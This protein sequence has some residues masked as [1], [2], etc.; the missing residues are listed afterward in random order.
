M[1]LKQIVPAL[2][3]WLC[4]AASQAGEV[5]VLHWWTSGGEAK[6]VSVLKSMVEAQGNHWKNFAVAGGGGDS[7]MTVLKTRVVS[8]NPPTAAQIKGLEIQ[9]WAKLGFL[10]DLN[11]VAKTNNWDTILPEIVANLMKYQGNYVA[12]PVNIHRVNWLWVNSE[13]LKQADA[14]APTTLDE[15]YQVAE[16][17]KAAGYIPL[18]HGGEPWQDITLF[19]VV[20]LAVLGADGFHKALVELD[21]AALSSPKMVE[22][23]THFR[24]MRDYIDPQYRGRSWFD[25]TAMV[26]EGEAAMQL[27]GD[28]AKGEFAAAGKVPG[29]DYLCVAAPG[30]QGKFT[31]NIDSFVFY[32]LSNEENRQAQQALA[33]TILDKRFQT[34]F[35]LNKG[36]MPVRND[37]DMSSFD[38]C[39]Q[40]SRAAFNLASAN[41]ALVPSVSQGMALTSYV[42]GAIFDVVS[43]FFNAKDPDPAKAARR[44][45]RAVKSAL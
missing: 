11:E 9:E 10:T 3:L 39:A 28:W 13:V 18:A 37:L 42:Q 16:Q 19:E 17:V 6:S 26:I 20:A 33:H 31:Y 38:Q 21:M 24:K 1:K 8:G 4:A 12:V 34:Q 7:A 5:E 14:A 2:G 29:R 15:F 45:A 36:S 32:R 23:F 43:D 25:A 30:T 44:L 27:M 40:D 41:H 35:N 22:V